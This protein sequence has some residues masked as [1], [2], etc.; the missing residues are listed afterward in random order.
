MYFLICT[1]VKKISLESKRTPFHTWFPDFF[2]FT[3]TVPCLHRTPLLDIIVKIFHKLMQ[4]QGQIALSKILST[5]RQRK[6]EKERTLSRA[7]INMTLY[8]AYNYV[9]KSPI[10]IELDIGDALRDCNWPRLQSSKIKYTYILLCMGNRNDFERLNNKASL[11]KS[12][13]SLR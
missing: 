11:K 3:T 13:D 1:F 12:L 4:F 6:R 2:A 10:L 9:I 5:D 7:Y 8:G